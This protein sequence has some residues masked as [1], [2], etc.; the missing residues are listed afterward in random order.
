MNKVDEELSRQSKDDVDKGEDR[1]E[2]E[3]RRRG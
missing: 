3:E 1:G 2:E